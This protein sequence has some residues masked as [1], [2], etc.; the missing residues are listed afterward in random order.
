MLALA[1]GPA[2]DKLTFVG[3]VGIRNVPRDGIVETLDKLRNNFSID[4]KMITGDSK[5]TAVAIGKSLKLIDNAEEDKVVMSGEQFQALIESDMDDLAKAYEINSKAVFYRVDTV[6]KADIISNLQKLDKIVAMT[7]DGV[8]DVI[9]LKRAN[10]SIVMESGADV[11]KEIADVI[12]SNN[13]LTVLLEAVIEGKG[14]YHKIHSFISY[15]ISLSLSLV[16]LVAMSYAARVETPFTVIQL[17]FINILADGPPAQSLGVEKI[18]ASELDPEPR[19][20]HKPVLNCQMMRVII[21]LTSTL[22]AVNGLL[23]YFLVSI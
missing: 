19:N 1:T 11:C 16:V 5:A 8:N 3:V 21:T 13:D 15:Q 9:S 2:Q 7:G 6:Q 14:I 20:V 10:L 4:V 12:L 22:I 17:L 23:Y 18:P